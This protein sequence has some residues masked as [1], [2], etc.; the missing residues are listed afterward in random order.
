MFK[1]NIGCFK[2][3]KQGH[4]KAD[5]WA[6]N[7]DK[8]GQ[9]PKGKGKKKSAEGEA[10][11]PKDAEDGVWMAV[12]KDPGRFKLVNDEEK[13][14]GSVVHHRECDGVLLFSDGELG[15]SPT[16]LID[17]FSPI[18]PD[19]YFKSSENEELTG[20]KYTT[21]IRAADVSDDSEDMPALVD[22]SD[23]S[24]DEC[25]EISQADINSNNQDKENVIYG[26]LPDLEGVSD[27]SDEDCH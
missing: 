20:D 19:D 9:G 3:H 5:C 14:A 6:N 2:C 17:F 26:D 18:N 15:D 16:F 11:T 7:C 10:N 4:V 27:S 24:D 23:S 22:I 13:Q 8:E 21:Y 1:E 12:I 25:E